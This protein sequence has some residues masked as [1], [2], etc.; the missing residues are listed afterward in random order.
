MVSILIPFHNDSEYLP[1]A[2][3]S[4][5][6]QDVPV[7]V[8]VI[9]DCSDV[10]PTSDVMNLINAISDK[11]IYNETNLGLA[12]A[13]NVGIRNSN[14]QFIYPLDADDWLYPHVL[15]EMMKNME[16]NDVVFGDITAKDDGVIHKPMGHNGLTKDKFLIDNPV[17]CGSLYR[18]SKL[19]EIGCYD[20]YPYSNYEDFRLHC[21]LWVANARFKY[22]DKIIYRHTDRPNSMLSELHKNSAQFK[23]FAQQPLWENNGL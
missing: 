14:Y 9:N 21:K 3:G 13:R 7:E 20:E 11:Y 15:G 23:K 6:L 12:G 4:C 1:K 18:K 2:L 10:P 16:D 19:I 8:I 5:L 17:W 22:I